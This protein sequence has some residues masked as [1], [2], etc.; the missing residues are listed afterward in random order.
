MTSRQTLLIE[1]NDVDVD[2]WHMAVCQECG[3]DVAQP[4]TD[5]VARNMWAARHVAGTGHTVRYA[6][7]IDVTAS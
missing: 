1:G 4:F 5:K 3:A 2:V 6:T 7:R